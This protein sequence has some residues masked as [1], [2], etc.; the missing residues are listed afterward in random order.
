MINDAP[1]DL[2]TQKRAY[3]VTLYLMKVLRAAHVDSA[4]SMRVDLSSG[5][6]QQFTLSVLE[7]AWIAAWLANDPQFQEITSSIAGC[8]WSNIRGMLILDES[9]G[10]R[11]RDVDNV[12]DSEPTAPSRSAVCTQCAFPLRIL[13]SAV[14]AIAD[15]Q[16]FDFP[17]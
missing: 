11:I 9:I 1:M 17:P 4:R 2:Y 8:R 12:V 15:G 3:W 14:V 6:V 13:R 10:L 7:K 5:I 16:G